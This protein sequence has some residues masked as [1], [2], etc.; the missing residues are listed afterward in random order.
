MQEK[1]SGVVA[2]DFGKQVVR[3]SMEIITHASA[4]IQG[5]Q[6]AYK[7]FDDMVKNVVGTVVYDSSLSRASDVTN[8]LNKSTSVDKK[9][10]IYD[11]ARNDM[12][13]CLQ[14]LKR[15]IRGDDPRIPPEM[16]ITSAI[17]DKLNRKNCMDVILNYKI[18]E[19]KENIAPEY[20]FLSGNVKG[21]NREM[22][23][24]LTPQKIDLSPNLEER[25]KLEG[26][27]Y[28]SETHS[29]ETI[30][31]EIELKFFFEWQFQRP[32]KEILKELSEE[33]ILKLSEI[34]SHRTFYF[35]GPVKNTETFYQALPEKIKKSL[36]QNAIIE[37]FTSL[38]DE[39]REKFFLSLVGAASISY[40]D[41][42]LN[43]A[44]IIHQR[45]LSDPW[46]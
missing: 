45:L 30:T 5:S 27:R 13:R 6:I 43:A 46:Q 33:E 36:P 17:R 7:L 34:F 12:A 25:L 18:L 38:S 19:G 42:P 28:N 21:S 32:V 39:T 35:E 16:V 14:V 41:L 40:M 11:I 2:P 20:Y 24:K 10:V 3:R 31:S 23:M 4:H 44:F 37:A 1:T 22:V 9:L 15:P 8:Y 29:I 26:L